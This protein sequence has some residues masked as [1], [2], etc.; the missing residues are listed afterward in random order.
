M[1]LGLYLFDLILTNKQTSVDHS[2]ILFD[3]QDLTLFVRTTSNLPWFK[4]YI[5]VWPN[6]HRQEKFSVSIYVIVFQ[7]SSPWMYLP[8]PNPLSLCPNLCFVN[9]RARSQLFTMVAHI[10]AHLGTMVR[11][12]FCPTMREL[13]CLGWWWWRVS[14]WWPQLWSKQ[15]LQ[16]LKAHL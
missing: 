5:L 11:L 8:L 4:F 15:T 9:L 10:L 2:R 13:G 14:W 7:S 3:F 12:R 16:G 1:C 6:S